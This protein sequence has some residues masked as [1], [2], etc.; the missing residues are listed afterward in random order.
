MG[1]H[2]LLVLTVLGLG[3]LGQHRAE[4][5]CGD[6]THDFWKD[7]GKVDEG[8]CSRPPET[9]QEEAPSSSKINPLDAE[10]SYP[11]RSTQDVRPQSFMDTIVKIGLF[12]WQLIKMYFNWK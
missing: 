1:L 4:A 9:A 7:D 5:S 12:I 2:T 6:T 10:E 3:L 8:T 11:E